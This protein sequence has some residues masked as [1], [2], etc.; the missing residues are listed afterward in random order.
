MAQNEDIVNDAAINRLETSDFPHTDLNTTIENYERRRSRDKVLSSRLAQL[1]KE[2]Q[3]LKTEEEILNE[4]R[5]KIN[6]KVKD[7]AGDLFF[8]PSPIQRLPREILDYIFSFAT[9][10]KFWDPYRKGS[11]GL[12]LCLVCMSWKRFVFATPGLFTRIQFMSPCNFNPIN[13]IST[14]LHRSG[15]LPLEI[16]L[17]PDTWKVGRRRRGVVQDIFQKLKPHLHRVSKLSLSS[18]S[19]LSVLFPTED[20]THLPMLR[21]LILRDSSVNKWASDRHW[22]AGL[23]VDTGQIFIPAITHLDLGTQFQWQNV[24]HIGNEPLRFVGKNLSMEQILALLTGTPNLKTCSLDYE[25]KFNHPLDTNSYDPI[26]LPKLNRIEAQLAGDYK[27]YARLGSF[28][29]P[30]NQLLDLLGGLPSLKDVAISGATLRADSIAVFNRN[31]NPDVCPAL[32]RLTFDSCS[33]PL[34][35]ILD[36]LKSRLEPP[37]PSC[38]GMPE[39]LRGFRTRHAVWIRE[40][41]SETTL[42]QKTAKEL[43]EGLKE[44]YPNFWL[45]IHLLGAGSMCEDSDTNTEEEEEGEEEE[46]TDNDDS[47][48]EEEG[49]GEGEESTDNDDL[50]EGEEGEEEE[51][52]NN[53][54]FEE[55]IADE[56]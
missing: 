27:S 21:Q 25:E 26:Y 28:R 6:D 56:N 18:T 29:T 17:S 2:G 53:D 3:T 23:R 33:Q 11:S 37:Q 14:S 45:D 24:L 32:T 44:I 35:P 13:L 41:A 48:E 20:N 16:F 52:T 49:E 38:S 34:D 12:G 1:E 51:S 55:G 7:G 4:D 8:Q 5:Q 46:S 15:T 10:G 54:D 30:G 50:E 40:R 9:G 22:S 36:M 47:E 31:I 43:V 19:L 42:S 39:M